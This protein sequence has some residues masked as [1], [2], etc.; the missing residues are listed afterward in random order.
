MSDV[1]FSDDDLRMM[2]ILEALYS[3]SE[4]TDNAGTIKLY[5]P[6]GTPVGE[7]QVSPREISVLVEAIASAGNM[8]RLWDPRTG[9]LPDA[10]PDAINSVIAEA[11]ALVNGEQQ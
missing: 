1:E 4:D 5:G 3:L 6:T 2:A 11:E 9:G 7:L 8:L 10:D